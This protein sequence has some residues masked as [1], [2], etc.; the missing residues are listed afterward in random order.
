[1]GKV[2]KGFR[3]DPELYEKF[4]DLADR[5]GLMITETFEKFMK[6][7]VEAETVR[8]PEVKSSGRGGVESEAR[9]LLAWLRK[10]Q[11]SYWVTGDEISVQGMLLQ[12]LSQVKDEALQKEIEE[13]LKRS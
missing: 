4:K 8:L 11:T 13:Q 5:N 12:M 6:A 7:S 9:V 10:G 2:F 3:F 1:M